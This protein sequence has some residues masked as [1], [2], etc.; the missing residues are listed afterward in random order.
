MATSTIKVGLGITKAYY[1]ANTAHT[2]ESNRTDA[3]EYLYQNYV[4]QGVAI[5]FAV[6]YASDWGYQYLFVGVPES[7]YGMAIIKFA[8]VT[9]DVIFWKR[10]NDGTYTKHRTL[11]TA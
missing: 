1:N 2:V 11:T 9:L 6:R 10:A 3:M 5:T 4:R 7:S 8:P